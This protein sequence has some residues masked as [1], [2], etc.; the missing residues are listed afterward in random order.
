MLS[1]FGNYEKANRL[2]RSQNLACNFAKISLHYIDL[3][4]EMNWLVSVWWENWPKMGQSLNSYS[5][6]NQPG[7]DIF[8]INNIYLFLTQ[9]CFGNSSFI[10]YTPIKNLGF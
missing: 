1:L 10:K 3:F 4:V 6:P 7:L 8:Y 2:G 5:V 9:I